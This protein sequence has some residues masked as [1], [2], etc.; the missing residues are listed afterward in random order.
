M[1]RRSRRSGFF[2]SWPLIIALIFGYNFIF[3]DD[4][5]DKKAIDIKS[6]GEIVSVET[7]SVDAPSDLQTKLTELGDKL[8]DVTG[9]AF[10]ILVEELEEYETNEEKGEEIDASQDDQEDKKEIA[11]QREEIVEDVKSMEKSE[12]ETEEEKSIEEEF[13]QL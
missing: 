5:E 2:L 7:V 8:K 6:H 9:E 4:N 1:S 11:E 3:D 10:D 13:R 12:E